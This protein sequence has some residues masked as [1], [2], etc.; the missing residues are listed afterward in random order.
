[1]PLLPLRRRLA[2]PRLRG[3]RGMTKRDFCCG[4]AS[5]ALLVAGCTDRQQQ[6]P[7]SR[8]AEI[9]EGCAREF[10]GDTEAQTRCVTIIAVREMDEAREAAL[11]RAAR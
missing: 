10:P 8:S 9:R 4:L 1:M 5:G 7:R 3:E 6:A 2:L 11:D